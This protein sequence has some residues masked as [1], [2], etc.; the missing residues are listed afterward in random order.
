VS[1]GNEVVASRPLAEAMKALAISMTPPAFTRLEPQS[2]SGDPAPGLEARVHDPL[3]LLARQWQLGEFHGDDA[4]TPTGVHVTTR[5]RHAQVWQPGDPSANRA[6][7][8]LDADTA[9]DPLVEREP[10]PPEGPGLRLRGEAG[11]Q[12]L[13][14]LAD[15][16]ITN[17]KDALLA[18]CPLAAPA[19]DPFD[20]QAPRLSA[21]LTGRAPDAEA[22]AQS[23]EAA[24][25]GA[26]PWLAGANN[27][28]H[29]LT[30][31]TAWLA[32]YR[33][34]VGPL[35]DPAADSWVHDRL[36]YRFS[37]AIGDAA[38]P[39]VLRAPA[40]GGGRVDWFAFDCDARGQLGNLGQ[41]GNQQPTERRFDLMATPL[42]FAGMPA[43]R[44]WQYEDGEVNLGMLE[45]QPHDLARL[46]LAEFALV[47]SNDWLVVP[48]DV[49]ADAFTTV[50]EVAYTTT[51][52][53]RIAVAAPDDRGRPGR[54]RMFQISTIGGDGTIAGLF[55]PPSALGVQ[56][57]DALED[58]LFLRDETAAMTWAV[59]RTVQGPSGDRRNRG[60]EPQPAPPVP[61]VDPGAELDYLL[62][63]AVPDNW[64][65]FVTVSVPHPLPTNAGAIALRKGAMLKDDKPV[66][67]RGVL[68][69]PTPLTIQDEE[70]ARE[71]VRVLRV[72]ALAR[73]ADGRYERW[74]GR[75]VTVG[76]GEGSSGLQFDSAIPRN[77]AR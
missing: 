14:D 51:F 50:T 32:W 28:A 21:L 58:V 38:K 9:L 39:T 73:H 20:R 70:V 74:I 35:P 57:G 23:L 52:N 22:A 18:A 76:R 15:A 42:R 41:N 66:L 46:C 12:L 33:A 65:P 59:E 60:D 25:G 54:F 69:R 49:E 61:G 44:Y 56:E 5:T 48:V 47:Y 17:V 62:A 3:W 31:A 64:I 30:V 13:D 7:R 29:A 11:A 45:S 27:P 40:F 24:G 36:E 72:P 63:T 75:R 77:T 67:P 19:A 53:E 71:G 37:V 55:V 43:D 1:G 68:L 34:G 2:V 16:G 10:S 8:P 4:G 26:P 6:P